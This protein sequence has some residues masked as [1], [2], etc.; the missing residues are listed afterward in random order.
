MFR[1]IIGIIITAIVVLVV[2]S[3]LQWNLVN[4]ETVLPIVITVLLTSVGTMWFVIL[5]SD[6]NNLKHREFK[7]PKIRKKE[8]FE[9]EVVNKKIY[10]RGVDSV[11]FRSKLEGRLKNGYFVNE[12]FVPKV[13]PQYQS[14]YLFSFS[15]PNVSDDRKS[16]KSYCLE[17][18]DNTSKNEGNLNNYVE[19]GWISWE[20]PIPPD[21][22]LN[23]YT[24]KM[25][26]YNDGKEDISKT[27]IDT[28]DVWNP[29]P[30]YHNP[31]DKISI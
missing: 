28:F 7:F 5:K 3:L 10:Y 12:I 15:T 11:I 30:S 2:S 31:Y 17:T 24:V 16:A 27:K 21:A 9:A 1:I 25:M 26:V 18:I 6:N 4:L 23:T 8:I 29:N 13:D 22:P 14:N 19:S 20:W